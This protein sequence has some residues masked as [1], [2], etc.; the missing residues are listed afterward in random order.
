MLLIVERCS[1]VVTNATLD[2]PMDG[3]EPPSTILLVLRSPKASLCVWLTPETPT[4]PKIPPTPETVST[5]QEDT[6]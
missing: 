1:M 4:L 3:L 5:V 6:S 2:I